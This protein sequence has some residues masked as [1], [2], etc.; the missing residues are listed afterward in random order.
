MLPG[1]ST[2]LLKGYVYDTKAAAEAAVAGD[3]PQTNASA[4]YPALNDAVLDPVGMD[5]DSTGAYHHDLEDFSITN[6]GKYIV[7]YVRSSSG[8]GNLSSFG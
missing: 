8:A 2:Y 1:G 7:F 4:T 3:D 6:A 5:M